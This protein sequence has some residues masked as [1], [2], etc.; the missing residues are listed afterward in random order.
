[1]TRF[2]AHPVHAVP[3]RAPRLSQSARWRLRLAGLTVAFVGLLAIG[4]AVLW[5]LS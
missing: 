2:Q 3:L 4:L 5:W 1:M